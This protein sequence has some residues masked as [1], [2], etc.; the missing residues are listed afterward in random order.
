MHAQLGE[1]RTW[2]AGRG[3]GDP[4]PEMM[5]RLRPP[6]LPGTSHVPVPAKPRLVRRL[7]L[8]FPGSGPV[9]TI[10]PLRRA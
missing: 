1:V 4:L 8:D 3:A 5:D 7:I 9:R 6:V 2:Y 10:L